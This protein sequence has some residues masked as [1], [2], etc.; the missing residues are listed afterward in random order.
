VKI[1]T[2]V[3]T[4]IPV[5]RTDQVVAVKAAMKVYQVIPVMMQ[6]SLSTLFEKLK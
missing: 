5:E 2:P 1:V 6:V 3:K 4:V